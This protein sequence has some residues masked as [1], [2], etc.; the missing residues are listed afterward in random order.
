MS[1]P[2]IAGGGKFVAMLWNILQVKTYVNLLVS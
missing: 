2:K 1:G